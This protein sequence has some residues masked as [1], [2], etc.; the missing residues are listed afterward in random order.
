MQ[1]TIAANEWE[2]EEVRMGVVI[3]CCVDT[4]WI[5]FFCFFYVSLI[6]LF[7]LHPH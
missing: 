7:F 5:I 3:L 1:T 4:D 6:F 2:E